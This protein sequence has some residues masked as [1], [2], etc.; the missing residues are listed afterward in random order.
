[1][2]LFLDDG[3]SDLI[4]RIYD[5]VQD[6]RAWDEVMVSF[7]RR[8]DAAFVAVLAADARSGE[9]IAP[10]FYGNESSRFADGVK[11]YESEL[12][13]HDPAAK[14]AA[15]H[16]HAGLSDSRV[17]LNDIGAVYEPFLRWQADRMG[18][19]HYQTR[20]L[21]PADGI[22]FGIALH[23]R[24]ELGYVD[25]AGAQLHALLFTHMSR[26]VQLASRPPD[27]LSAEEAW[28][29]VDARGCIRAASVAAERELTANDGLAREGGRLCGGRASDTRR[30]DAALASALNAAETG[31]AGGSVRVPRP[32][33]R[34]DWL[35]T[36]SPLP[37]PPAPWSA[38]RPAALVKIVDRDLAPTP[39]PPERLRSLFGLTHR[40]AAIAV[41][42]V[43]D[44]CDLH[45]AAA[46]LGIAYS[47]ARLHL[48]HVFRK[49]GVSSRAQLSRL[50]LR[51]A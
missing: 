6:S 33:G 43:A 28:L 3:I 29:L 12:W 51:V 4:G 1:L 30:I 18:S 37:R 47:T 26:A 19:W 15:A 35:L 42:L 45:A 34:R 32:S 31:G 7:A 22:L 46:E 39:A 10:R 13:K 27:F 14:W 49:T 17:I 23:P 5:G 20:Y 44:D 24:A 38:L 8:T 40:E 25:G 41:A 21:A 50:M 16:P 11:E 36:I 9:V 2:L 48:A